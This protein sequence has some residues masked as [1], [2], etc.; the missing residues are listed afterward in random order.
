MNIT[1][2]LQWAAGEL[3]GSG[4]E[5]PR[6][7]A[8]LLLAWALGRRREDLVRDPAAVVS[9]SAAERFQQAVGRRRSRVPLPYITGVQWFYGREFRVG[10]AVLIPR[11]ETELLISQTLA[12]MDGFSNPAIADVGTGSGC[13]ALTL[14]CERSDAV[15]WATDISADALAVARANASRLGVDRRIRFLRGDLLQP[16]FDHGVEALDAVVA[17]PPYVAAA[18]LPGL[19]PE[20]RDYEPRSALVGVDGAS[21]PDGAGVYPHLFAQ[22]YRVL[23]PG[24]WILVEVGLGQA[25]AVI[26]AV[27][28]VGYTDCGQTAD[29]A[30]IPRGVCG[31]KSYE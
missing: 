15:L 26:A 2:S 28:A 25:D 21:G 19:Q 6:R 24:G 16:L 18:D 1:E 12:L 8:Q 31:R 22:A 29:L 11:P 5:S 10:P 7:E 20:V 30:G 9:D 4:V 13:I 3:A 17:N 14:A 23:K 27:R